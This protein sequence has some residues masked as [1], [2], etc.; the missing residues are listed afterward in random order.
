MSEPTDTETDSESEEKETEVKS[1]HKIEF[2]EAFTNTLLQVVI[3]G[4]GDFTE[5][6]N[7]YLIYLDSTNDLTDVMRILSKKHRDKIVGNLRNLCGQE[8]LMW[9]RQELNEMLNNFERAGWNEDSK[10]AAQRK[11]TDVMAE[12]V[13]LK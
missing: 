8:V 4:S 6:L 13:N 12:A 3:R 2:P 5:G 1:Q 11:L 10:M 9:V 7:Q